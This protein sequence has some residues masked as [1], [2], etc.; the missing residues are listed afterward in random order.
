MNRLPHGLEVIATDGKTVTVGVRDLV[1]IGE[2]KT[3]KVPVNRWKPENYISIRTELSE[4]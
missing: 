4:P 1:Y 2:R 3:V